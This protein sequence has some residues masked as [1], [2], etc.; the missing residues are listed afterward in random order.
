MLIRGVRRAARA[1]LLIR[2][3]SCRVSCGFDLRSVAVINMIPKPFYL[4]LNVAVGGTN[5]WFADTD[6]G[7]AGGNGKDGKP[8]INTGNDLKVLEL[9]RADY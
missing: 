2:Y 3:E 9:R 7:S 8:W 5:G 4:V 1:R 6:G